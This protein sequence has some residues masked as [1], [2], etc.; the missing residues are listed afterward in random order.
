VRG[1]LKEKTDFKTICHKKNQKIPK[2]NS[3][4]KLQIA[5]H[6]KKKNDMDE[7]GNILLKHVF[8]SSL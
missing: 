7:A 1:L 5:K 6:G 8:S 4:Q 2:R 3:N